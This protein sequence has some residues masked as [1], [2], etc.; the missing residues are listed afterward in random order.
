MFLT[1]PFLLHDAAEALVR[2]WLGV[3]GRVRHLPESTCPSTISE[4]RLRVDRVDDPQGTSRIVRIVGEMSSSTLPLVLD[5]WND[6]VSPHLVHIDVTE[7]VIA[8]LATMKAFAQAVDHLECRQVSI[9]I[10]GLDPSHPALI[11]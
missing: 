1:L 8:D 10:V 6:V 4:Q 5:A 2:R 7:A 9:R 3:G 11:G